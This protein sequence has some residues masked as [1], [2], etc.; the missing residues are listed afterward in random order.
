MIISDLEFC[1]PVES[2]DNIGGGLRTRVNAQTFAAHGFGSAEADAVA[3]GDNTYTFSQTDTI[4]SNTDSYSLTESNAYAE[5]IAWDENSYS[6]SFYSS[7]SSF[8][9]GF[10]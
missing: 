8:Y 1:Y 2:Q 5:A 10:N 4:V 7:S 6:R 3:F 9:I